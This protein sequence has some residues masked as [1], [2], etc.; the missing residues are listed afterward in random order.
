MF[1]WSG[2]ISK[3]VELILSKIVGKQLD[4]KL[5]QRK[6]A[7]K[8]FLEFHD[9]LVNLETVAHDFLREV[10]PEVVS[11][12]PRLYRF[13]FTTIARNADV[14]SRSF[15]D[16]FCKL[17]QVISIYDTQLALLLSGISH[18]KQGLLASSF[19]ERMKFELLPNPDSVFFI[20]YSAPSERLLGASLE[21]SY[22]A[23]YQIADRLRISDGEWLKEWPKDVLLSLVEENLIEGTIPD[24]RVAEFTE[25]YKIVDMYT[26]LLT[27]AREQLA[28]FMREK[29][30][31]ED[32]LYVRSKIKN[33]N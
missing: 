1:V 18:F 27:K 25:F 16:S 32:L 28:C 13:P 5:D 14:A 24:N 33:S 3:L 30:T 21:N 15:V 9:A 29:F 12:N 23:A 20:K 10:S 4:L 26:P 22:E 31:L 8:V 7:A 17:H 19:T 2:F 6:S 11:K